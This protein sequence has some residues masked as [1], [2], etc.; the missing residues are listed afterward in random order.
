MLVTVS[1]QKFINFLHMIYA[2]LVMCWDRDVAFSH[3][4]SVFFERPAFF[5]KYNRNLL[6]VQVAATS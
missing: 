4:F 5:C 6:L 2:I 3:E 1:N